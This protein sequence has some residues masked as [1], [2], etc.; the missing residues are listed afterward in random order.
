MKERLPDI[1]GIGFRRCASSWLHS[2]LNEYLEIGKPR[3]GV[4]FFSIH[5][6]KGVNWYIEQLKEYS[7]RLILL[8]FSVSY[9]YPEYYEKAAKYLYKIVPNAKLFAVVRNPIERAFSDYRRS[10]YLLEIKRNVSFEEM[11][12]LYPVFLKRGLYAKIIKRYLEFFPKKQ[13]LVLFYD[14][15]LTSQ[16]FFIQSL[17]KY[18]N[19]K[20]NWELA[21][22]KKRDRS[23]NII[24]WESY[25]KLIFA[26]KNT[27]TEF[28]QKLGIG[29]S[30]ETFRT[31]YR[32]IYWKI[33]ALNKSEDEIPLAIRR[34]LRNYYENDIRELEI[35]TGRNLDNWK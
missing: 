7:K 28:A 8:E 32:S 31:K 9:S 21:S 2:Y 22:V 30:W 10:V 33:L 20:P 23:E 11:I 27:G 29:N 24:K 16:R 18:L 1:I 17:F 15:L 13:I 4:H 26:L 25:N 5:L 35:L 3:S 6:Q 34:C 14:D 19:V 12:N